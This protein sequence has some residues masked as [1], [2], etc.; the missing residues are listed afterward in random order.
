MLADRFIGWVSV[1]YFPME[2]TAK[3]L[4]TILRE[5][6]STFDVAESIGTDNRS[7]FR[8]NEMENFLTR[9]G[10]EHRIISDFNPH[11]N[12]RAETG[13]KTA[14]RLLMT[15]NKSDGSP[16]W[17][18]VS[19]APL[20][21]RNTPVRDLNLSPAQLLFCRAVKDMLPVRLGQYTPA[22]SGLT[23]MSRERARPQTQGQ[24]WRRQGV[25]AHKASSSLAAQSARIHPEPACSRESSQ[26]VGQDSHH[27]PDPGT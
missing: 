14:K 10:A 8:A 4:I 9:W 25:R 12:L 26:E 17:D 20:Q 6:L 11:S 13:V 18:K 16:D 19:Q 24:P 2:A 1:F 23:V 22:K 15:S 21:H 5:M 27:H 7:Q 3:Q